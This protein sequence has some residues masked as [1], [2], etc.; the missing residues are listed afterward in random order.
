MAGECEVVSSK[1]LLIGAS[2]SRIYSTGAKRSS[3]AVGELLKE[4]Q[5]Y[6]NME[7]Y[8]IVGTGPVD[9]TNELRDYRVTHERELTFR[10][11][12]GHN[13]INKHHGVQEHL[14]FEKYDRGRGK[15]S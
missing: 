6:H 10:P 11:G 13:P 12:P 2:G 5:S 14:L 15:R 4:Y 8:Q 7:T 1:V 3:R 9:W